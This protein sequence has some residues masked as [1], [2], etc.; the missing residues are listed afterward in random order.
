MHDWRQADYY[1]IKR[2][3]GKKNFDVTPDSAWQYNAMVSNGVVP[4]C[5]YGVTTYSDGGL[6]IGQGTLW[7]CDSRLRSEFGNPVSAS[8][9]GHREGGRSDGSIH[10]AP[11]RHA[12]QVPHLPGTSKSRGPRDRDQEVRSGARSTREAPHTDGFPGVQAVLHAKPPL[13]HGSRRRR[14]SDEA[15]QPQEARPWLSQ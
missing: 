4:V 3:D 1:A 5:D 9:M 10:Q 12:H 7:P 6:N 8:T 11:T 15:G 14:L 13:G 2:G